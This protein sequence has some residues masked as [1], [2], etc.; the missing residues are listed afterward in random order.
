MNAY[1]DF[2]SRAIATGKIYEELPTR[3][4]AAVTPSEWRSKCVLQLTNADR[5]DTT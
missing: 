4:Q 1:Q 5:A 2:I 3:I